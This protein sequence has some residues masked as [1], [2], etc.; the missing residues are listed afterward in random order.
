MLRTTSLDNYN[1][2]ITGELKFDSPE[3]L[4]AMDLAGQ[5]FFTDSYVFGG[6][7]GAIAIHQTDPMDPMFP[8]TAL[9][10]T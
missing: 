2:W 4:H 9:R 6:P 1:K 3:V 5:I 8:A 10:S 7:E